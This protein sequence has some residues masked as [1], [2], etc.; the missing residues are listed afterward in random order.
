M[1]TAQIEAAPYTAH[2]FCFRIAVPNKDYYIYAD[3]VHIFNDWMSSLAMAGATNLDLQRVLDRKKTEAR[4]EKTPEQR[5]AEE[6][7]LTTTKFQEKE[8]REEVE[9]MREKYQLN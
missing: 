8:Q 9:R 1:S 7:Y 2:E 6:Y 4:A 5:K 3:S